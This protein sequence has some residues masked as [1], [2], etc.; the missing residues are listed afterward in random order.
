MPVSDRVDWDFGGLAT[1]RHK[2]P[3][4]RVS[5]DPSFLLCRPP[6]ATHHQSNGRRLHASDSSEADSTD[7][8]E[9]TCHVSDELIVFNDCGCETFLTN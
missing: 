8:H 6:D 2:Q 4:S 1:D 3:V 7:G 9:T 5:C